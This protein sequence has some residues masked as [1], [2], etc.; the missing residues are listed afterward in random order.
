GG[1]SSGSGDSPLAFVGSL[2]A[3]MKLS[4]DGPVTF[5]L[6][7]GSAG[8]YELDLGPAGTALFKIDPKAA[9]KDRRKPVAKS[10]KVKLVAGKT[11]EVGLTVKY[12]RFTVTVDKAEALAADDGPVSV[13]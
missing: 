9:E 11:C 6:F 1:T 4:C 3:T 8:G 7:S 5:H 13:H 10:E 2:T 12:P